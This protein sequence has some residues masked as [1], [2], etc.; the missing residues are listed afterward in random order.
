MAL[1]DQAAITQ[2]K[3]RYGL[4]EDADYIITVYRSTTAKEH[5]LSRDYLL[6]DQTNGILGSKYGLWEEIVV[7]GDHTLL[8]ADGVY[9]EY[10][11]D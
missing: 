2:I 1:T 3:S 11:G 8:D 10:Q 7:L 5:Q 4:P 9:T 6:G